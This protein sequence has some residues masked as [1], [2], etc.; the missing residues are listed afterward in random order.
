MK[1]ATPMADA[2]FIKPLVTL[3]RLT[4]S[5]RHDKSH[6]IVNNGTAQIGATTIL[7]K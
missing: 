1:C 4:C 3:V 7:Q 5:N 6:P 2:T